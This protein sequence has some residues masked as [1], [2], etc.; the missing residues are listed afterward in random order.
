MKKINCI[1]LIDDNMAD[2]EFHKI[3]IKKSGVCDDVRVV[4][5]GKKAL[6]YLE[7]TG[8]KNQPEL[9]PLPELIYLDINMPGMNGF[10]FLEAYKK[11]AEK[12]HSKVVIVM[13][14]TSLNNIDQIRAEA[15]GEVDEFEIKPLTEDSLKNTI[16]KYF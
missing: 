7:N 11:T 10:E 1:L 9:F 8:K 3:I 2:N 14:T 16:E 15:S 5:D 12:L 6:E 4:T 13:L